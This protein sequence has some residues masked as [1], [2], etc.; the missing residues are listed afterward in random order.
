MKIRASIRRMCEN[1][2]LIRRRRQVVVVCINPKHKQ[3][4]G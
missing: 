1:C 4:Q 3:R 2:R